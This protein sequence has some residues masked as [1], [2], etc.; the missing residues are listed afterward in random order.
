MAQLQF[1]ALRTDIESILRFVYEETDCRVFESYSRPGHEL[2]EFPSFSD[3]LNS[4]VLASHHGRYLLRLLS[5][6]I[7][8]EP[9]IRQHTLKKTGQS[10]QSIIGPGL[11]QIGESGRLDI[12]NDALKW[13]IFS[14]YNEAG[15]KNVY[16][17][18]QT[19]DIDWKRMRRISGQIQRHIKNKLA[20]ASVGSRPVLADAYRAMD[21]SLTLWVGPGIVGKGSDRLELHDV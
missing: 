9:I 11:Y 10:R 16:G 6:S 7:G 21:D 8:C 18:E 5:R 19:Q 3:L 15:A 4:D 1:F 13:S 2:R 14:H 17:E 12:Q 20:V